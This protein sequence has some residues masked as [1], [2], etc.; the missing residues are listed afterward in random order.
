MDKIQENQEVSDWIKK[1]EDGIFDVFKMRHP[2]DL[3]N[4]H[5]EMVLYGKVYHKGSTWLPL[6]YVEDIWDDHLNHLDRHLYGE[7]ERGSD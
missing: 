1:T 3:P 4:K 6:G 2:S 5:K 7:P